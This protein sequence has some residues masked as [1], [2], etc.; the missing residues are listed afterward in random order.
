MMNLDKTVTAR[1]ATLTGP[2]L[3]ARE[4]IERNDALEH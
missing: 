4:V 1:G 2:S 3:L